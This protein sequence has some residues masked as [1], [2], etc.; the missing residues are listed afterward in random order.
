MNRRSFIQSI[1]AIAG[2]AAAGAKIIWN[3]RRWP[4]FSEIV[5]TT[6]RERK[7]EIAANIFANNA[8]YARLKAAR[9]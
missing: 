6:L 9:G 1:A 7:N 3:E 5:R 4:T 2:M 8:L